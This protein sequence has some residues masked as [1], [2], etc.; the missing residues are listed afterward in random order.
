[1][2]RVSKNTRSEIIIKDP[3]LG[4]LRIRLVNTTATK[5]AECS[6]GLAGGAVDLEPRHIQNLIDW[7]EAVL[8][9]LKEKTD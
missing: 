5:V 1:M 4:H 7:F 6:M 3:H 8:V 2:T 9:Q